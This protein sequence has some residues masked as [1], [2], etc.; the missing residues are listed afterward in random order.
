MS[1]EHQIALVALG[2]LA[3]VSLVMSESWLLL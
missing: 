3:P 1:R 2:G